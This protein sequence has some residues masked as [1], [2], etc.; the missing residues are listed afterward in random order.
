MVLKSPNFLKGASSQSGH[1]INYIACESFWRDIFGDETQFE[2]YLT[3]C[4]AKKVE[5]SD[6][7]WNFWQLYKANDFKPIS[8]RDQGPVQEKID[9]NLVDEVKKLDRMRH[10][11]EEI[12]KVPDDV[13]SLSVEKRSE[14]KQILLRCKEKLKD[15]KLY[16]SLNDKLNRLIDEKLE[17]YK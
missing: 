1:N 3:E 13:N 17:K 16:I 15:I 11:E 9:N 10:V 7:A 6:L 2:S 8:Y 12:S 5:K 14:Y 4:R